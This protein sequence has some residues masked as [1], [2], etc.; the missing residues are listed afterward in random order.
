MSAEDEMTQL[1]SAI[2][3]TVMQRDQLKTAMADWY[4]SH[5]GQRYPHKAELLSLDE[6]LSGLDSRFKQ[7]WDTRH[8]K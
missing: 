2:S 8:H 5:P 4:E 1:R 7:L 3:K 6:K